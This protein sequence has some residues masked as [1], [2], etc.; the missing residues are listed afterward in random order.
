MSSI[1]G[2]LL[3]TN[4]YSGLWYQNKRFKQKGKG[5]WGNKDSRKRNGRARKE[6]RPFMCPRALIGHYHYCFKPRLTANQQLFLE[7]ELTQWPMGPKTE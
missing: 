1:V 5:K 7:P 6:A 2:W 4:L 3:I